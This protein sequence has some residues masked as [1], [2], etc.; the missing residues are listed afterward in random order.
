MRKII[1]QFCT[2]E[3]S[4]ILAFSR[5][6]NEAYAKRLGYEYIADTG[7]NHPERN[8]NWEKVAY[9]IKMLPT[10][11]DGSL[12]VWEDADSINVKDECFETALHPGTSYGMVRLRGGLAKKELITWYNSGVIVMKNSPILRDFFN[13]VW[14]RSDK[15]SDERG[16]VA[17]LKHHDWTIGNGI[18]VCA[19]DHKWNRWRN[20]EHLCNEQDTV[21][22]SWHGIK[23]SDK[24]NAMKKFVESTKNVIPV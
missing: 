10:F 12:V 24:L 23:L 20:N 3:Q 19:L 11:E 5:P 8:M 1:L 9:I 17:E 16:I 18:K 6:Y 4:S 13:R 22:Q 2:E 21:V 14:Q 15:S 7:R